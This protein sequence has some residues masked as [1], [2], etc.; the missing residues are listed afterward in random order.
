MWS[1]AGLLLEYAG[2]VIGTEPGTLGKLIEGEPVSDIVAYI[3]NDVLDAVRIEGLL[4]SFLKQEHFGKELYYIFGAGDLIY[5]RAGKIEK[6]LFH[7]VFKLEG[8]FKGH[9]MTDILIYKI[10]IAP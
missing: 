10:S 9:D 8:I 2:E 1:V 6:D 5:G 4:G 3:G 7:Q